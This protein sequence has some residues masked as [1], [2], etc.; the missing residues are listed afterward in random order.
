MQA[1]G[2]QAQL[3]H[4][5]QQ[6]LDRALAKASD[7]ATHR[8]CAILGDTVLQSSE[9]RA[10]N[11]A[12]AAADCGSDIP[13]AATSALSLQDDGLPHQKRNRTRAT[14]QTGDEWHH[15]EQA[16]SDVRASSVRP[17]AGSTDMFAERPFGE[18]WGVRTNR[19]QATALI[20]TVLATASSP[21]GNVAEWLM[22]RQSTPGSGGRLL[23]SHIEISNSLASLYRTV[24]PLAVLPMAT[25]YADDLLS[26][27][28]DADSAEF[29]CVVVSVHAQVGLWACH[30]NLPSHAH[31]YLATA[32]EI[33]ASGRDDPCMRERWVAWPI[34]PTWGPL[35]SGEFLATHTTHQGRTLA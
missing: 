25:A 14:A 5:T 34:Q 21:L 27:F 7:E 6:V 35:L 11:A 4:A 3:R 1:K 16:L 30:A 19:R 18:S 15:G 23:A 8:F 32:C 24:N 12:R 20:A 13:M 10:G 29:A 9:T 28:D 31:R 2:D 22:D 17:S 33:A 26:H